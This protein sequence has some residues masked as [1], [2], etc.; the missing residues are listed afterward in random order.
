MRGENLGGNVRIKVRR[1][2]RENGEL[3]FPLIV[4]RINPFFLGSLDFSP[5]QLALVL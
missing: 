5:L 2:L 4:P 3:R 1:L